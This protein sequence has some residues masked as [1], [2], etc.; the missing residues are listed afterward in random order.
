[1]DEVGCLPNYGACEG[2]LQSLLPHGR[3][4]CLPHG[5][6]YIVWVDGPEDLCVSLRSL[7]SD[8]VRWGWKWL[9]SLT[10]GCFA[11]PPY[12]VGYSSS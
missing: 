2:A 5:R 10:S 9:G 3:L 6:W 8:V 12:P 1:M 11:E 4:D 7:V